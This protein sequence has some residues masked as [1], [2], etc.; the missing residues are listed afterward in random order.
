[1]RFFRDVAVRAIGLAIARDEAIFLDDHRVPAPYV[2]VCSR[3]MIF[4]AHVIHAGPGNR[5][6][7]LLQ[8]ATWSRL[9]Y[10]EGGLHRGYRAGIIFRGNN[11]VP[12]VTTTYRRVGEALPAGQA[13]Y[14]WQLPNIYF[15]DYLE[16]ASGDEPVEGPLSWRGHEFQAKNPDG[17]KSDWVAFTYPFDDTVLDRVRKECL[18]Q[19]EDLL[20][21]GKPGEAVELLRKVQST[22]CAA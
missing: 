20:H 14:F 8:E 19:G 7:P 2:D 4:R 13:D 9:E 18:T 12:G 17:T 22:A 11:C 21:A 1:M 15:G 6:K 16:I 5:Q 10:A 3:A